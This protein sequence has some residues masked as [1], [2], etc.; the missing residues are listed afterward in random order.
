MESYATNVIV[1]NHLAN[2][3]AKNALI[4]KRLLNFK[5]TILLIIHPHPL[6]CF[7]LLWEHKRQDKCL[8]TEFGYYICPLHLMY[9]Y[10]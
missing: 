2:K 7:A 10:K 8:N 5:L 4:L 1:F 3:Y 9:N 6:H